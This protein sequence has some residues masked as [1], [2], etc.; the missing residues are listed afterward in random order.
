MYSSSLQW[1]VVNQD[2]T[3]IPLPFIY[4]N[5]KLTIIYFSH[6]NNIQNHK[7]LLNTNKINT[8][9][10][11]FYFHSTEQ[12]IDSSMKILQPL[13]YKTTDWVLYCVGCKKCGWVKYYVCPT[14]QGRI[15]QAPMQPTQ[16]V[17]QK[18]NQEKNNSQTP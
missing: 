3:L 17:M 11:N 14:K 16:N 1:R 5:T 13:N 12:I 15:L 9:V 18:P 2:R 6:G 7:A 10:I 4:D 8:N